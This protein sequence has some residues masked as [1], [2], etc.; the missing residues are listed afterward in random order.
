MTIQ[1]M[2]SMLRKGENGDQILQILDAITQ[3]EPQGNQPT[4]DEIQF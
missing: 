4:L 1:M 3:E 2:I